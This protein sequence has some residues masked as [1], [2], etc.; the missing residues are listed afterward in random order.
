VPPSGRHFEAS[1]NIFLALD[2]IDG[3]ATRFLPY[4]TPSCAC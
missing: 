2:M 1:L 4:S 3:T